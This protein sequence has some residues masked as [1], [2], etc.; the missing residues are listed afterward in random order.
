MCVNIVP[1]RFRSAVPAAGQTVEG[2]Y[3]EGPDVMAAG[4]GSGPLIGSAGR[5]KAG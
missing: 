1:C 3:Y 2:F 4:A 5:P